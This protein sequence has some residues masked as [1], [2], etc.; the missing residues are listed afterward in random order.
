MK[1]GGFSITGYFPQ[2]LAMR[3]PFWDVLGPKLSQSFLVA[4]S[5]ALLLFSGTVGSSVC[6]AFPSLVDDSSTCDPS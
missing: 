5:S 4:F 1:I 3:N 2:Q 6:L